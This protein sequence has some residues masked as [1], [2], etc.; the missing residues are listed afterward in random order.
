MD[1]RYLLP[2]LAAV[3]LMAC[4]DKGLI[5]RAD[6][7]ETRLT[8]QQALANQLAEQKDSLVRVVLDADAFLG[9]MD[10][11]IN[12]VRGLPRAR[13][14]S[15]DPLADQ[16]QARKD[17]QA[18]VA[19]LVSR[20]KQTATQLGELQKQ[21]AASDAKLAEQAARIEE[22]AQLIADLGATIDR[23]NNQ[24]ALLEAR[25]D[26]LTSA[27]RTLGDRHYKAYVAIGTERELIEKGIAVKEG[28]ANLLVARPGR[29]LQPARVLNADA[30]TAIDQR[31]TTVIQVPDSTKRYRLISR[32]SL[33]A[34]E[35]QGRDGQSFVGNL[36]I[37]K[38][39]EFWAGSRFLILVRQ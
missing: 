20:A 15:G 32:Q 8:E 12:T 24:I 17:M 13:R 26:S 14:T 9:Q 19:A 28:G 23:Q 35:V 31:E 34:A 29:T 21:Q 5:A 37:R 27:V 4:E 36:K 38:P 39:E 33:D 11:A 16:L 6:T 3:S 2:G 7:L 10:S 30:F 22:D 25:L 1:M 18:R